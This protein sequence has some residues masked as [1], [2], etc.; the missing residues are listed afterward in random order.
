M[1]LYDSRDLMSFKAAAREFDV[2]VM[3][4]ELAISQGALRAIEHE[5][6]KWLQRQDVEQFVK[7]TIKQGAGNK[8]VTRVLG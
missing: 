7:R 8:V 2:P 3:T 1:S 6:A 5:G 4:L